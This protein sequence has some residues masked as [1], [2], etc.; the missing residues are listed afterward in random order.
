[1]LRGI[2]AQPV[3]LVNSVINGEFRINQR[4]ATS[5][6][7][8]DGAY[9]LDRWQILMNASGGTNPTGSVS[10]QSFSPGQT[11][12]PYEPSNYLRIA[13]TS[14]GSSLGVGSYWVLSQSIE[15]VRTF[16]GQ[17]ITV[18]FWARSSIANKTIGVNLLQN[19]GTGGSSVVPGAGQLVTLSSTWQQFSITIVVPSIASK[20]IGTDDCL[21]LQFWVQAGSSVASQS[22][23]A[24][25]WGGTGTIDIANVVAMPGLSLPSRIEPRLIS[26]ELDLCQRYYEEIQ[27]TADGYLLAGTPINV[28][29]PF[30]Q[31]KRVGNPLCT[32]TPSTAS[33]INL[34]AIFPNNSTA[35]YNATIPATGVYSLVTVIKVSAEF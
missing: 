28:F 10:Q 18:R 14:Q 11:E 6:S 35:A 17:T 33:N 31:N 5:Y 3:S 7:F 21:R 19:F 32:Q 16:A 29:I 8:V 23:A 24:M 22:G 20:T 13:N 26:Q 9:T 34:N 25:S 1:M 30:K 2:S 4:G 15:S 27:V 12:V